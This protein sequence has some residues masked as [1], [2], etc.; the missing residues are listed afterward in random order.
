MPSTLLTAA[1]GSPFPLF[2]GN[3]WS[4]QGTPHPI[5][6]VQLTLSPTASGNAYVSLSGGGTV[7]SGGMFLSGGGLLDGM[8][9]TPGAGYFIPK[10]G[11]GVS[12]TLQIYATCDAAGSGQSRLF[13]ECF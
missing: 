3:L 13:W 8:V 1:S 4:G 2:S 5:G 6:G 11:C 9:M 12:G 7:N 10:I